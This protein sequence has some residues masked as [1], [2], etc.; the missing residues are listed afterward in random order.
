VGK[1]IDLT[2][3]TFGR[4]TVLS[5]VPSTK[6][7]SHWLCQCECGSTIV[8]KLAKLRGGR[9]KSCGCLKTDVL[10]GLR[11]G[12]RIPG[13][14]AK[15]LPDYGSIK[16][17]IFRK[18]SASAERRGYEFDLTLDE[19]VTISEQPCCY[20]GSTP[21]ETRDRHGKWYRKWPH[22]G[23]DRVDN[24]KGYVLQNVVPCCP[25][26][27]FA[28]RQQTVSDFL[29]WA[30]RIYLHQQKQEVNH[31]LTSVYAA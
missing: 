12:K 24:A 27:N 22:N 20:C 30:K 6:H 2:G 25:S 14:G 28:K 5:R 3:Q 21:T 10:R 4:L 23:V 15:K 8:A 17:E 9:T 29:S 1:V 26:C 31:T 13:S 11:K 19:F 18:Y 7:G 16:R